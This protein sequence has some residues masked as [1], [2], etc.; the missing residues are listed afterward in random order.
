MV[1]LFS[2]GMGLAQRK[3]SFE[4]YFRIQN[5]PYAK[6]PDKEKALNMLDVYMPKKGS[7][8]PVVLWIHDGFW[9]SGDKSEVD[10]KPDYFASSGYIFV[11]INYRL[12][13][14]AKLGD[15][16]QDV[17]NAI[18]WVYQNIIHYSGDKSKLFVMGFGSGAQLATM[19]IVNEKYLQQASGSVNMVRG[20][21][22]LDG[23]GFDISKVM[24]LA[25]NKTR[26]GLLTVMGNSEKQWKDNSAVNHISRGDDLPPFMIGYS[27]KN[28]AY[29]TD[30]QSLAKRLTE[31][32][33]RNRLQGYTH[34]TS[35]SVNKD[36]G[37]PGDKAT[38]DVVLFIREC[39]R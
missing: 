34:K 38:E 13:P 12:A 4:N 23:M 32:G 10:V 22:S 11:S 2:S 16:L 25:G 39:L 29:Q 8:S 14:A 21:I 3:E 28:A 36:L 31:A 35:G 17:A 7:N 5:V 20:V 19:A 18:V 33:V 37:K 9:T 27:G 24:P 26:E 1:I 15:Q 6:L 30:A